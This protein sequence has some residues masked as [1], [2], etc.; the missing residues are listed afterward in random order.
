MVKSAQ[1]QHPIR[2]T[3]QS[4]TAK[5]LTALLL[6]VL[7]NSALAT[8]FTATVD[9]T[10]IAPYE[11]L[12]L[13][14]RTDKDTDRTPD[15]SALNQDFE[16][17]T[18][19]QSRQVRI[20]NGQTESWLDWIV[21]LSPKREGRLTIPALKLGNLSSDAIRI[22]VQKD[23]S[24]SGNNVSPVFMRTEVDNE[25][26]YVQQQV[27]LTLR[28][29]YRVN[30]YDDSRLSPLNID[31][32]IVQ[33]LGDTRKYETIIDGK[34][35]GVFELKFAIHPQ[36]AGLMEIPELTFNGTMAERNDPFGSIFSM[37]SGKPVV[38]RSAAITL[39]VQPQ[40]ASYSGRAWLPASD[41]S[42]NESWSQNL[43]E[44]HVG[45]AI[46][47]TIT[48]EA[49]GLTSAQLPVI[50]KPRLEHANLYPDQS[51]TEDTPTENGIIGKRMDAVAIIPTQP[52]EMTLPALRYSWFDVTSNQEKVAELP[53]KTIRVL[54]ATNAASIP[55]LPAVTVADSNNGEAKA[56]DCDC[57]PA[58]VIEKPVAETKQ[59]YFWPSL[60]GLFALLW[61]ISTA[62]WL[63]ARR[64]QIPVVT[65]TVKEDGLLPP[66]KDAFRLLGEGCR[67]GNINEVKLAFTV[68]C[69]SLFNE[70][71]LS[72]VERCLT[73]LDSDKLRTLFEQMDAAVYSPD[74]SNAPF[75]EILSVCEKLRK[76]HLKQVSKNDQL[77]GLYPS[78]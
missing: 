30:L 34:R 25:F 32:A 38:A 5:W 48:V 2:L 22:Q 1:F 23:T 9:R 59:A 53:A 60:T 29:F 10:I 20:V 45:D 35:Y 58:E 62:L 3:V 75:A 19:R 57:P 33:Q 54:P 4:L 55:A 36:K 76:Q 71:Q 16:V 37:S 50:P 43:D 78:D 18:T 77:P 49:E 52:G 6:I 42:L 21:T 61:L 74:K 27:V 64:Q 11:T 26:I 47:R 40:P 14:L 56:A 63:L 67:Q 46:T 7:A 15:L 8:T 12:D 69:Q 31:G 13:T 73:R 39:N 44:V 70:Q 51:K 66:E 28:V 17:V 68:W 72:T 41:L 24:A 65:D